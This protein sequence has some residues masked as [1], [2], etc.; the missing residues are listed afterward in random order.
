MTG[1]GGIHPMRPIF[2]SRMLTRWIGHPGNDNKCDFTQIIFKDE[3]RA[4]PAH[5]EVS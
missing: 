3:I 5:F 2:N 1:V 4:I